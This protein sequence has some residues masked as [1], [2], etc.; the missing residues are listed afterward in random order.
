MWYG[1]LT[2]PDGLVVVGTNGADELFDGGEG[3]V[4]ASFFS[5][6]ILILSFLKNE[7]ARITRSRSTRSSIYSTQLP[8]TVVAFVSSWCNSL[9]PS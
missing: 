5:F 2:H 8:S 6:E 4:T 7:I 3:S 9:S 1:R